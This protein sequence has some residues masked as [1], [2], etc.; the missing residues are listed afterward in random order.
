M[1][2]VWANGVDAR[3]TRQSLRTP[4]L[5]AIVPDTKRLVEKVLVQ[6]RRDKKSICPAASASSRCLRKN[7]RI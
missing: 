4:I 1:Q 2:I 3:L 7:I 5:Q 6:A